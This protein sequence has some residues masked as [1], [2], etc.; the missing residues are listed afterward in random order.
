MSIIS[1]ILLVLAV[2]IVLWL[3]A[4]LFIKKEY[5]VERDVVINKPA[6]EVFDYVKYLKNQ[7]YFSKWVMMDPLL[8]PVYTGTDGMVGARSAW[9]SAN[10]QVGKGEQ[11]IIAVVDGKRIDHEVRFEKPM[12]NTAQTF[13]VVEPLNDNQSNMKWGMTGKSPYPLNI[14]CLFIPDM[15]GKDMAESLITLKGIIER[16]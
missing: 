14:M 8:K 9:D 13:M 4:A 7:E 5:L 12:K 1:I 11:E 10:K 3:V 6:K 16:N 2:I 15:L